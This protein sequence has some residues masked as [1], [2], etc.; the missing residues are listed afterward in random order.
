MAV[1][2]IFNNT[3]VV[4]RQISSTKVLRHIIVV[5]FIFVQELIFWRCLDENKF[6]FWNFWENCETKSDFAMV[7]RGTLF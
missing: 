2:P 7:F 3:L 4:C 5:I 1:G 6:R